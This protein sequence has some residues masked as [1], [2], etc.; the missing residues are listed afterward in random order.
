MRVAREVGQHSFRSRERALCVNVP[1]GRVERLE[2]RLECRL[3]G[4]IG[5]GAEELQT[6]R[7]MRRLQHCQH[8]AAE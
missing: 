1:V 4:E 7:L 2:E 6:A 8:L 3:I 5:Q